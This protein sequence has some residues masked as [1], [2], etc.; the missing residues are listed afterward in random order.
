MKIFKEIF[1]RLL[2]LWGLLVFVITMFL[3]LVPFFL[4]C[5]FM[6]EP[7]KTIRFVKFSRIWMDVFF[8]LVGCSLRVRGRE[9]F[10][11][12][13][14]YIVVCNHN[15]IFDIMIISP[16]IP[17]GNKTI[18]KIE[19]ARV[20]V[21]NLIYNTGTV[22]VDRKSERSRSE[23]FVQMKKVLDMGLHMCIYP[24][25]TRNRGSEALKSFHNGAFKLAK[26]TGKSIIPTVIFNTKKVLPVNKKFFMWPNKMKM[27]FLS[28]VVIKPS[29]DVDSLKKKV[30]EI[31]KSHYE[32][33]D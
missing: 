12:G 17:G 11:P 2:T 1:G 26:D 6:S 9:N 8:F 22:L 19:I 23:S 13:Q 20:P 15:S 28:P 32:N 25:G 29:D 33:P 27:D 16:R 30:F 18:A 31:M 14:T 4:F 10:A 21:F 7:T 5:Y 24:E 3:F